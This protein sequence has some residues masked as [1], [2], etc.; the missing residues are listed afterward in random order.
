MRQQ[1]KKSRPGRR[2]YDY[3]LLAS[4]ILLLCF[5]LIMLYSTT[6]YSSGISLFRKQGL[7]SFGCLILVLVFS[8]V[9][10]HYYTRFAP[11]LFAA[12]NILQFLTRFIGRESHGAKRWI[13]VSETLSIQPAEMAKLAIIMYLPILI[14]RMGKNMSIPLMRRRIGRKVWK[15]RGVWVPLFLGA[16]TSALTLFFTDNLSTA[17]IIA[18]ITVAIVFVAH[19]KTG[20]WIALGVPT[21]IAGYFGAK[22]YA[23]MLTESGNFRLVRLMVWVDP[24]AYADEGGYQVLQGLYAIGSGGFFGKGLGNSTQKLSTLPEAQNDMIFT[25]ICEELGLFGAGLVTLLFVFLL[26]RLVFIACNAPDRQGSLMVT[27]I[28]AHISLQVIL[29]ICVML[30]VIPTTGITLPFI[31][32]G[33]SAIL[34][35]MMEIGLALSVSGQIRMPDEKADGPGAGTGRS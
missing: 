7:I 23:R 17:V 16:F 27:G 5:G 15:V 4:V 8:Q 33:G 25:I 29:N 9:D 14:T 18:G 2:Y 24:A 32:Y 21:L 35:L 26:Y 19:P 30:N 12:A 10:Y 20:G 31:S 28:F 11:Y 22:H 3:S 1:K 6:A 34:F 13:G